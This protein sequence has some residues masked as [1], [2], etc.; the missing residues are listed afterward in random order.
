MEDKQHIT[1]FRIIDSVRIKRSRAFEWT[2]ATFSKFMSLPA[3]ALS[4]LGS[5]DAPYPVT[6]T[7]EIGIEVISAIFD[8]EH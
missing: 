8:K 6:Q 7:G 5:G 3:E 4:W 1:T 2:K